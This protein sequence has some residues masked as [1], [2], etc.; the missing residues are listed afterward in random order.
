EP[1]TP[2]AVYDSPDQ[3]PFYLY[4]APDGTRV[5]FLTTEPAGG[6]ALRVAPA[7]ASATAAV[8]RQGALLYWAW[9]AAGGRLVPR[10]GAA[11][12]AFIG[13]VGI[14]GV[15]AEPTVRGSGG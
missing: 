12:D 7:D 10:G 8:V 3:P 6:I 5:S 13:E 1:T 11:A 4:W 14:D 9:N 2:A 15:A